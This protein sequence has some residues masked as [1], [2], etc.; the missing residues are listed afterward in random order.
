MRLDHYLAKW[1][2]APNMAKRCPL[3]TWFQSFACFHEAGVTQMSYGQTCWLPQWL[4]SYSTRRLERGHTW[5]VLQGWIWSKTK[6]RRSLSNQSPVQVPNSQT[7]KSALQL[8]SRCP[9][10]GEWALQARQQVRADYSK[11][12]PTTG[13][14]LGGCGAPLHRSESWHPCTE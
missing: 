3:H 13:M 12:R 2:S 8:R 6:P 5:S 14:W 9:C 7:S 4:L 1:Q 10:L 11:Q